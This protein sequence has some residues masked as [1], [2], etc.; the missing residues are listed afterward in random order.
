MALDQIQIEQLYAYNT[1]A[2]TLHL[3]PEGASMDG[4]IERNGLQ[5][6]PPICTIF[7]IEYW[8]SKLSNRRTLY[9]YTVYAF[10]FV[11]DYSTE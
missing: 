1:D 10:D 5:D 3:Y 2:S 4:P 8:R 7:S 11:K 9:A 6:T